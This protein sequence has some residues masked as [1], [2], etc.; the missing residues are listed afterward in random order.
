VKYL[1]WWFGFAA[2][3]FYNAIEKPKNATIL[4]LSN[5]IVFPLLMVALLWPLQLDGLWLNQA[6]TYIPVNI[7]AFVMLRKTQ[8]E[9]GKMKKEQK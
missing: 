6:A 1:F 3:G 8:K 7:I 2:L 4:T 5:V 9:I